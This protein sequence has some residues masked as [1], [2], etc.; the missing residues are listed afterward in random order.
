MAVQEGWVGEDGQVAV[1]DII[2]RAIKLAER[3]PT[4]RTSDHPRPPER[5]TGV[6]HAIPG[7]R[8]PPTIGAEDAVEMPER[9]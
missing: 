8:P 9:G 7:A 4:E 5:V 2:L 1:A 6:G 3:A